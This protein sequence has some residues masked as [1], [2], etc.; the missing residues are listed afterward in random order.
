MYLLDVAVGPIL[1]LFGLG[2]LLILGIIG[3]IVFFA[4]K[5]LLKIRSNEKIIKEDKLQQE[6]NEIE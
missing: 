4:V 5:A 6:N 2:L 3:L 1:V